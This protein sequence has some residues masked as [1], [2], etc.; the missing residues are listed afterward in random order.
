MKRLACLSGSQLKMLALVAM[1]LD[2]IGMILFPSVL[3][4]RLV[5][6]MAFP[7]FAYMIAEGC[8][9]TRNRR[10]YLATLMIAALSCQ[11]VYTVVMRS[12]FQCIFVTFALAVIYIIVY[13]WARTCRSF[14]AWIVFFGIVLGASGGILVL[15]KMLSAWDFGVDY[16][17]FGALLPLFIYLGHNRWQRLLLTAVGL[18]P[19][20]LSY[21]VYQWWSFVALL[22][23]LF[24]NGKRGKHPMKYLFYVY[25]PLHLVIIYGISLLV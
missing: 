20:C 2:H 12:A 16:G 5:G 11:V 10:R 22:P 4:L 8:R 1:T 18:V 14:A 15:Q 13:E 21:S 17:V 9:Y 23:L 19:I 3:W 7:I 24:Y 6:R 25:Y